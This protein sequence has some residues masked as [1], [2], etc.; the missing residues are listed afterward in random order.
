MDKAGQTHIFKD[1]MNEA[2][3]KSDGPGSAN[4]PGPLGV[5]Q[6][7]RPTAVAIYEAYNG[8]RKQAHRWEY[9]QKSGAGFAE[10]APDK[11]PT[12]EEFFEMLRQVPGVTR[13]EWNSTKTSQGT[14]SNAHYME[15]T[16]L[17]TGS[18]GP[19]SASHPIEFVL[20]RHQHMKDP[21]CPFTVTACFKEPTPDMVPEAWRILT[22][23]VKGRELFPAHVA[24]YRA[25]ALGLAD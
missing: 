18:L 5:G 21:K 11:V 9:S 4:L 15:R 12:E 16:I 13:V 23:V 7:H 24:R 2:G 20:T 1:A 14:P 22:E 3:Q 17:V 25:K 8:S 6:A 19:G 10:L